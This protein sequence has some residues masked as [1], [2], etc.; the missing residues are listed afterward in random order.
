MFV[1]NWI[2]LFSLALAMGGCTTG[3]AARP[4]G[5]PPKPDVQVVEVVPKTVPVEGE[6]VGTLDGM[7]NA[8]IKAQ[9]S[10]TILRQLYQE[11][12]RVH[13]GQPLFEIDPRPFEAAL[14]QA[15]AQLSQAEGQVAQATGQRA[16]AEALQSQA[17][18]QQLQAQ[19][20]LQ[21]AQGQLAQAQAG[22]AQAQAQQQKAQQDEDRYRPLAEQ[23]AVTQQDLDNAVQANV[24]ARAQ[25]QAARA[26]IQTAEGTVSSAKAQVQS[27]R[28]AIASARAQIQSAN[29]AILTAQAQVQ[30]ARAQ[31]QSAELNLSYTQVVSPIQGLAGLANAQV[32]DLV[33]P[34]TDAL[35]TVSTVDPIKVN[36]NIPEAEYLESQRRATLFGTGLANKQ[37]ARFELIRSDGSPYSR[38]GRFFAEDRNVALNT[39]AI[40]ITALFPN[41]EAELKPGQYA[42]VRAVRYVEKNVML[43]PQRA[44]SELQDRHQVAVVGPDNKVSL[45]TVE[46]GERVGPNWIV[47]SGLKAGE[48]VIVEGTQKAAPDSVVNP[49]PY[50]PQSAA[51]KKS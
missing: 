33:G 40:R 35:T 4:P 31:I 1:R 17:T 5:P 27:A 45:R 28:S 29:A 32:G 7:V 23:N 42:R 50:T 15:R 2:V 37:R 25:V 22:L 38:P 39:G 36:F 16:Q 26:Q 14:A 18:S 11:G 24:S 10:G 13:Q 30:T 47:K 3:G 9:V 8:K 51:E 46:V 34:N 48:R 21:Q 6:W 41:P 43:V 49:K 19:A 44:I 12:T 20:L